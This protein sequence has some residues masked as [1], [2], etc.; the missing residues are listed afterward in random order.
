MVTR[1]PLRS[2]FDVVGLCVCPPGKRTM[3]CLVTILSLHLF[4]GLPRSRAPDADP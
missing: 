2:Y 3:S 4:E 1:V